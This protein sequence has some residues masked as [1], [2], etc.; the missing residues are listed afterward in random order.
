MYART[1]I[2][3]EVLLESTFQITATIQAPESFESDTLCVRNGHAAVSVSAVGIPFAA[4]HTEMGAIGYDFVVPEPG[5]AA[6]ALAAFAALRRQRAAKRI[7]S[8][9]KP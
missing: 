1:R 4:E 8:D 3:S 2:C 7:G 6:A 5:T 9:A